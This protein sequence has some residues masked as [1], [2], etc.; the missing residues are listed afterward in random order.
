VP[1]KFE[2]AVNLKTNDPSSITS[3]E[4]LSLEPDEIE[5]TAR[6][7]C[8]GTI[9]AHAAANVIGKSKQRGDNVGRH[10]VAE[11]GDDAT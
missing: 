2:I 4:H 6:A 8:V 10:F 7:A 9:A 5:E 11:V 3:A 1:T